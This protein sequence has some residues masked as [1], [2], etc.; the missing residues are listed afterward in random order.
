M[1]NVI[2][3]FF[4]SP[5][6]RDRDFIRL[7]RNIMVLAL[8]ATLLSIGM[9]VGAANSRALVITVSVLVAASLL[10]VVALLLVLRG[11]LTMAKVV[12]PISLIIAIT[13]IALSTNTIHDISVIAYPVIIIIAIFLQ[14]RRA[15]VVTTPLTVVA[16]ALLGILDR[17]G[18]SKSPIA[19]KTGWDDI[20]VAMIMLMLSAAILNLLVGRLRAALAKA[21]TNEQAQSKANHELRNLQAS[22]EQ[23]VEERTAELIQRGTELEFANKQIERK[24]TQLEALAQVMQAI[25]SVH[26]LQELLPRIA[27][28]ISEKFGFYHVGVFLLDEVHEYAVLSATNSEGGRKMLERK[29]RLRVGA[30]GIVGYVTSTGEPRVALDVGKDPVFFNNPD[31]PGTHS[32][33]ALPLRNEVGVV[34]ALDVQS[35]EIGAFTDEDIQMLSLLADQVSLAIE[36]ARLFDETRIALAEAEAVSRQFTR[37]SWGR[38][39]VEHHLIG[40][41]YNI[42]GAAP[43][44]ETIDLIESDKSKGQSKQME[45]NQVLVPIELRGETIGTLIV[46]SPATGELTQDQLDLIKAVAERVALSA[47]NAR[48]FEETTRRA[49]RERLVS[50]ITGKVRSMNDPQAMIQVA[51]EE[52]RK[53]LGATHVDVIPQAVRGAE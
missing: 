51:A 8:V 47:E 40:Y 28:V 23:R 7:T 35:T 29:H 44:N 14:G 11:S 39:P 33:M 52:L 31:L 48:L 37:E 20:F 43:L 25:T 19:Y 9:V 22:L 46:Q 18:L 1:L 50:D 53:A 32:E 42:T 41:R 24:A 30:E 36:N 6:D 17:M 5:E 10:E 27:T 3:N 4:R 45:T 38:L 21:E 49:E 26:D 15:L 13:I 34:G 2:T 12:V 16:V